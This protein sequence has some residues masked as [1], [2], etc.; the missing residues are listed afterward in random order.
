M[1]ISIMRYIKGLLI[2]KS[3]QYNKNEARRLQL[4]IIAKVDKI[5]K[6]TL[7]LTEAKKSSP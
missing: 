3:V 1:P 2:S 7:F 4:V 5:I 6:R